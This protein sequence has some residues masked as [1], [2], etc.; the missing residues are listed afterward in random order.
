M[1]KGIMSLFTSGL[2]FNP[3]VLLGILFGICCYIYLTAEQMTDLF[4]DYRFYLLGVLLA[5]LYNFIFKKVYKEGGY[6]LD[7]S[8][9][10]LNV[11]GSAFRFFLSS[12]LMISFISMI[13]LT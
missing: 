3:M 4:F 10:M 1:I 7:V 12:I 6:E 9:T 13:S 8:A 11:V 2:I 5:F